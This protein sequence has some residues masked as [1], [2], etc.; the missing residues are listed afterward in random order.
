MEDYT[1]KTYTDMDIYSPNGTKIR[2]IRCDKHQQQWGNHD[3][4]NDYLTPGKIYTIN[5]TDVRSSH[6]KV[7]LE[8][9]PNLKF[10]SVCFENA[11]TL[12]RRERNMLI[13]KAKELG[14]SWTDTYSANRKKYYKVKL[15]SI[16]GYDH[17]LDEVHEMELFSELLDCIKFGV[18][19]THRRS[20]HSLLFHFKP[21]E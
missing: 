11:P 17:H 12:G 4:P 13:L 7:F 6:T 19:E 14:L 8:E 20:I 1:V 9:F 21:G 2:F 15:Y 3:D 10:N 5:K 18:L 16:H